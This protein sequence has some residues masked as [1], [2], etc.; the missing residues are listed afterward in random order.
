MYMYIDGRIFGGI[1]NMLV[2]CNFLEILMVSDK[3]IHSSINKTH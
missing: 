3:T 1:P 2:F